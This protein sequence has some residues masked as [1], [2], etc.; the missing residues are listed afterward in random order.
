MREC[1][2]PP[3]RAAGQPTR[4]KLLGRLGWKALTRL[5]YSHAEAR[6]DRGTSGG[7]E[8]VKE[9]CVTSGR[10]NQKHEL[11]VQSAALHSAEP[12]HELHITQSLGAA[13]EALRLYLGRLVG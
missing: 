12:T 11:E 1:I 5:Y 10:D 4:P 9:A 2:E 6:D 3:Q 13:A 7:E 8:Q